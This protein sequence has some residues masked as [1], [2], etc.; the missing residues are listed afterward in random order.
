MTLATVILAYQNH[1][2]IRIPL[3]NQPTPLSHFSFSFKVQ[4]GRMQPVVMAPKNPFL[5]P[6]AFLLQYVELPGIR[7]E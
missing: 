2:R 4:M 7:T 3:H 1:I 5:H 6:S